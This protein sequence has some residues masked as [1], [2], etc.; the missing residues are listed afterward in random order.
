MP[1]Q[2][3]LADRI[4]RAV[5]N[6][7][8][9]AGDVAERLGVSRAYVSHWIN[10]RRAPS[11]NQLDQLADALG[12]SSVWLRRGTQAQPATSFPASAWSFR[13][14]PEDGGRDY[15]N[16]NVF[17]MP[18]DIGNLTRETSQNTRDA[19]YRVSGHLHM[20]FRLIELV[21]GSPEY[22][23]FV[24]T[25]QLQQL[26]QHIEQASRTNSK[27]GARLRAGLQRLVE[28]DRLALLRI[29][30]FG[31]TGLFGAEQ[32]VGPVDQRDRNPFAALVKNNL[33][34]SKLTTTAGGSFGLGKAVLW[35]CSDLS[36]VLFASEVAPDFNAQARFRVAGKAELT[37]HEM[38]SGDRPNAGP[39]WYSRVGSGADS[40]W[41]DDAAFLRALQLDRTDL[42]EGLERSRAW[43]TSI[44]I[45]GFRNP[46]AEGELNVE[47]TIAELHSEIARNCWLLMEQ[48]KLRVTV[49]H[50]EGSVRRDSRSV[51]A[52]RYV[53][54]LCDAYRRHEQDEVVE[55]LAEPGD[56]RRVTIP[57]G[58]TRT[59]GEA[60]GLTH[61]PNDLESSC[62]LLIR[63]VGD[64]V[65]ATDELD[66]VALIRGAGM[67]VKYWPRRNI[68]VGGR[69]FHAIL[70]AG[71]AVTG[72]DAAQAAAEQMLRTAE[73]PAHDEWEYND[74][75]R[76]KYYPGPKSRL[77][78]LENRITEAIREAIRPSEEGDEEGPRELRRLL[79]LGG[80]VQK[81]P[82]AATIRRHSAD[83]VDGAWRVGAEVH[84]NDR[85]KSWRIRPRLWLDVEAGAAVRLPW[86]RFE[87]ERGG[88]VEGD[89]VVV[90]AG[91]RKLS[92]A[93]VSIPEVDG[94]PAA[95]CRLK[96]DLRIEPVPEQEN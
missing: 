53:P 43:G 87:V 44:L 60:P 37:W 40:I 38:P 74:D 86:A 15:G 14:G 16:P 19:A 69:R 71:E 61:H 48:G 85:Q 59:R 89:A 81:P 58:V 75:L 8:L 94:I 23:L 39:G 91:T 84:M 50:Y 72:V 28:G 41:T 9:S 5:A 2:S 34:S 29:D 88:A 80:G 82:P 33:D 95:S 10:G 42:P 51:D 77:A 7:G 93:G 54:E 31:T 13:P 24:E 56:V 65:T 18:V 22:E 76:D 66:T 27:L 35:R 25:S 68:V 62:K 78:E 79:Q 6:S 12:V 36:T 52:R 45:V 3:G 90:S 32:S 47:E 17:A 67:V 92:F 73:P 83:L 96:L 57:L 4:R 49:E 46:R 64:D 21:A 26:R 63:L 1:V 30:D 20:R 70:L 11:A 55:E